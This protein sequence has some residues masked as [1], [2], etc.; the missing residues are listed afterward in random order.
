MLLL[1]PRPF[2]QASL[3]FGSTGQGM[4]TPKIILVSAFLIGSIAFAQT[5]LNILSQGSDVQQGQY[6]SQDNQP[7]DTWY[8][9]GCADSANSCEHHAVEHGYHHSKARPDHHRC[10]H[11]HPYAC[12]GRN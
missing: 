10:D 5:E 12:Y 2:T 8:F 4:K 11:H 6:S 9:L 3:N 7:F 1:Y